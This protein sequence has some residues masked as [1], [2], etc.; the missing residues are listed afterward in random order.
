MVA[1]AGAAGGCGQLDFAPRQDAAAPFDAP[2][3]EAGVDLGAAADGRPSGRPPG[4]IVLIGD[5]MGPGQI[6][7]ASLYRHGARNALAM[8]QLASSGQLRTGS[9]SGITDSA[10]AA[11]VMATGVYT[12]NGSV[13]LDRQGA[14]VENLVERAAHR[15]WSTGVVTTTAL[16]HATP[17]GF[18]AHVSSRGLMTEIAEQMVRNAHPDVMLGG[19]ALYFTSALDSELAAAGYTRVT[20]GAELAAAVEIG[21]PRLFGVFAGDHLALVAGRAPGTT[22]P[23]LAQMTAAAL[24]TLDRDPHGFLL[25]V[26]GGRIDHGGHANSLTDVV[27]ETLGFDDAV[28]YAAA[29]SRGRGNVTVM[30][31]ADHETG[32]L[33]VLED[34]PAG[35]Y[36]PVSWRWGNHTN[37]RVAI[38]AEGPGT[39]MV[40]GAVLD[41]RWVHAIAR[42]RLDNGAVTPPAGEPIPDGELGDLR[43][44]AAVQTVPTDVGAGEN[45]LDALWLDATDEGLFIGI[46][47]LFGW[48]GSAVEVWIDVDPLAGTG[49]P[50]LAGRLTDATGAADLMLAASQ[51]GPPASPFGADAVLVSIGG[52]DP[53]LDELRDDGGLRGLAPPFGQPHELGWLPV[54]INFGATRSRMAPI[55]RVPGQGLEAFIPWRALYLDGVLPVGARVRLIAMLVNATGERASNQFLPPLEGTA[56]NSGASPVSPSGVIEYLIDA[57]R[58]GE[59]DG[60]QAPIVLPM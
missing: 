49:L 21:A 59:V 52:A 12:Y 9:P 23:T 50:A 20:T 44:L 24:T 14:P 16:P 19:G 5:G 40:D 41:H 56:I 26:E 31:T 43:H 57:D 38:F 18:T 45:Q 54:A 32:G 1:V 28:A 33:E 8:Q 55:A 2:R 15:G 42:S 13:G 47:G 37:T 6:A 3:S 39:A 25:V 46:E 11:T 30:V 10:A 22:E 17:A 36:P 29:W 4:V 53:K 51:L 27:A 58:D 7:A 34:R 48:A 60:D 35:Q